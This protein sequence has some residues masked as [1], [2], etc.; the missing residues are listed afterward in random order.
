MPPPLQSQYGPF[1]WVASQIKSDTESKKNVRKYKLLHDF[2]S[3]ELVLLLIWS[4]RYR[5]LNEHDA[6]T[7]VRKI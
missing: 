1:L 5:I 2:K 4:G 6:R 7:P 3:G